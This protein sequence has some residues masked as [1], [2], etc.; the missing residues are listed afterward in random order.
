MS[1]LVQQPDGAVES[2]ELGGKIGEPQLTALRLL[3]LGVR[4]LKGFLCRRKGFFCFLQA[5]DDP[6]KTLF[7]V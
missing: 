3:R 5:G 1:D 6:V 7:A 4:H 2:G